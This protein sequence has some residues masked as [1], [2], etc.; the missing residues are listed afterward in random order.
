VDFSF[1]RGSGVPTPPPALGSDTNPATLTGAAAA[2]YVTND[3]CVT[4]QLVEAGPQ[5]LH[6]AVAAAFVG[7]GTPGLVTLSLY[8]WDPTTGTW[9]AL[10]TPATLDVGQEV[11]VD[12][13]VVMST[14]LAWTLAIVASVASPGAGIYTFE[15]GLSESA[16]AGTG[17]GGPTTVVANQ[18]LPTADTTS[19]AWPEIAA[20][21]TYGACWG[22]TAPFGAPT[23]P[24]LA[25]NFAPGGSAVEAGAVRVVAGGV[26]RCLT[27]GHVAAN[28]PPNGA[29]G[30]TSTD[31][32]GNEWLGLGPLKQGIVLRNLDATN[33]LMWDWFPDQAA[34]FPIGP[35][36][37]ME[38]PV[39][40]PSLIYVW[41]ATAA[42]GWA[43]AGAS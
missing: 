7:T 41:G 28:P 24:P 4:F 30:V 36:A 39:S 43:V 5:P 2:A 19:A 42:V 3:N 6:L 22:G 15:A 27:G 37:A 14:T 17:G 29:Q 31:G 13:P 38:I 11:T 12:V 18:G 23:A 10:P 32:A 40:D 25:P 16:A 8:V 33:V 26:V 1:S 20:N 9:F 34:G 35:G 21:S